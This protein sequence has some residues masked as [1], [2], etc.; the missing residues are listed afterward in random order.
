MTTESNTKTNH[1]IAT[2]KRLSH[3][4]EEMG[5]VKETVAGVE[6]KVESLSNN[7][8]ILVD[9]I[10]E[11]RSEFSKSKET[12][13]PTI[14][15]IAM[16]FIMV[17]GGIFSFVISEV[18]SDISRLEVDIEKL[19][20]VEDNNKNKIHTIEVEQLKREIEKLKGE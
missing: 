1:D 20:I 5:E 18:N 8:I 14:T 13:W 19:E 11:L 9:S 17:F 10:K 4:E 16:L 12:N 3:V 15:A 7:F 6:T 2:L